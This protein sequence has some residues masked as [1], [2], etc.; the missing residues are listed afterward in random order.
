MPITISALLLATLGIAIHQ[1]EGIMI[2]QYNKK[3][4]SVHLR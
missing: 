1:I 4:G 3:H 2:K